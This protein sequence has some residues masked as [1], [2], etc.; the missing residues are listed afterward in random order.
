MCVRVNFLQGGFPELRTMLCIGGIDLRQQMDVL[1]RGCHM[2]VATPGRL[3]D[4]LHK[5]RMKLDICR[6]GHRAGWQYTELHACMHQGRRSP[7][8]CCA[9]A[10]CSTCLWL[11]RHRLLLRLCAVCC[12]AHAWQVPVPG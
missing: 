6:W 5:K 8:R 4:L 1:K 3:K 2:V 10:A 7:K 12:A 11:T 9:L